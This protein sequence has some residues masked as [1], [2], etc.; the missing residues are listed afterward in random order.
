MAPVAGSHSPLRIFWP[1]P[2][3]STCSQRQSS[4]LS[5]R[6]ASAEFDG[7]NNAYPA[8]NAAAR[9]SNRRYSS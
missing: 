1:N 5:S 2:S 8:P 7:A 6:R 3:H 4:T 9:S